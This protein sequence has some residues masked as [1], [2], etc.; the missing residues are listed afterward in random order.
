MSYDKSPNSSETPFP[1]QKSNNALLHNLYFP[2]YSKI[3]WSYETLSIG[4]M[5][6]F[7]RFY[8]FIYL[9]IRERGRE[10]EKRERNMNVWLPLM[11]PL[12]WTWPATQ[13]CAPT[14]NWTL[15]PLVR[16]QVLNPL[17]HTSQDSNMQFKWGT[18]FFFWNFATY[19]INLTQLAWSSWIL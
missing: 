8:L 12:L 14:G 5:Y 9:F 19:Q 3:L 13:A 4:N 15:N 18:F 10:G 2:S 17:R 16:R 11:C 7:K 1:H 6:F